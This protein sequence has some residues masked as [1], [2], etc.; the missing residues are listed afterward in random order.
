LIV[1]RDLH[2]GGHSTRARR[3]SG[4]FTAVHRLPRP[5]GRRWPAL[6]QPGRVHQRGPRQCFRVD[7]LPDVRHFAVSNGNGEDPIVLELPVR[8]FDSPPSE[9]D[10]QSSVA[11]RYKF[12]ALGMKSDHLG[13][14]LKQIRQSRVPAVRAGQRPVLP[15][16]HMAVYVGA[17]KAATG[18]ETCESADSSASLNGL[19]AQRVGKAWR[20]PAS[21]EVGPM[22]LAKERGEPSFT[23]AT[24]P[25]DS[26]EAAEDCAE[27]NRQR[28]R[29]PKLQERPRVQRRR[30][31]GSLL[32]YFRDCRPQSTFV[33]MCR[34]KCPRLLAPARYCRRLM[35]KSAASIPAAST[36]KSVG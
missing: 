3:A 21:P 31:R 29:S 19:E 28:A 20:T 35:T 30:G 27:A 10:D 12:V 25:Q 2:Y 22:R 6:R 18:W 24:R 32:P 11:L 13:S 15:P 8:G 9:A 33:W 26:K 23:G 7:I 14:L 17:K 16:V 4:R 36:M 1:H 5:D 34:D